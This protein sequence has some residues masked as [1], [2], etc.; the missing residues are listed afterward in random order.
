MMRA[1]VIERFGGPEVLHVAKV[2]IPDVQEDQVLVKVN[3]AG[4]GE[5]DPWL[6][7]GG[8][9]GTLPLILGSDGSGTVVATGKRTKRLKI[10]DQV[11]GY[12]FG[13]RKGGFFAEY[14]AVPEVDLDLIPSTLDK[15]QAGA[16]GASGVTGLEGLV[17]LKLKKGDRVLITG[18]S[19]GVGHVSIQLAKLMGAA[20]TAVASGKD[21]IA[22]AERLGADVAVDG[23]R[24]D[25]SEKVEKLSPERFDSAL[26]FAYSDDMKGALGLVKK[27]GTIA[28]PNGV[29]PVPKA[30]AGTRLRSFDGI[31]GH[32][33]MERLTRLISKGPFQVEI[34]KTYR[35]EDATPAFRDVVEHH[36]GKLAF[37]V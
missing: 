34:G 20:V 1:V 17:V 2:P 4:I 5:W 30:T 26:L 21:G 36:V 37:K 23:H 11:Y 33:V 35:L 29:E 7:E 16:L 18:A 6:A 14:A 10:G 31:P 13:E 19:G 32:E 9:G 12:T 28:Y 25:V 15:D 8:M 27:G 24:A 22:L 3:T